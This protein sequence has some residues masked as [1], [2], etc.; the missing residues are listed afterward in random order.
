MLLKGSLNAHDSQ[1]CRSSYSSTRLPDSPAKAELLAS[2]MAVLQN[3]EDI[4]LMVGHV[5]TLAIHAE[6]D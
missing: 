3:S 6:S 2:K 1:F 5:L 4:N